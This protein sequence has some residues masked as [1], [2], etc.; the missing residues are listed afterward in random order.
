MIVV[1]FAALEV[2]HHEKATMCKMVTSHKGVP[3]HPTPAS[4]ATLGDDWLILAVHRGDAEGRGR[5]EGGTL[6][7]DLTLVDAERVEVD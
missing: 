3:T 6:S 1:N 5:P 7:N 2:T 4:G